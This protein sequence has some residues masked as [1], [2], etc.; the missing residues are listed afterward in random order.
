MVTVEKLALVHA[1]PPRFE[2]DPEDVE[3]W[4]DES[5]REIADASLTHDTWLSEHL[6]RRAAGRALHPVP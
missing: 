1:G 6:S 3:G 5:W 2:G 4:P